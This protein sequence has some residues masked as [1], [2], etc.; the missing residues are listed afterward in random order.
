MNDIQI[1][2]TVEVL[3]DDGGPHPGEHRWLKAGDRV[4]VKKINT[5]FGRIY[6]NCMYRERQML[7]WIYIKNVKKV[8]PNQVEVKFR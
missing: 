2:D 5:E 8:I 4:V 1:G 3:K 6:Y 7:C